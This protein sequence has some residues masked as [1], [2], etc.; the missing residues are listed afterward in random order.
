MRSRNIRDSR[1]R[2]VVPL[3]HR[4]LAALE[5]TVNASRDSSRSAERLTARLE[6]ADDH[7]ASEARRR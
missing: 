1:K 3:L 2:S 5:A 4:D 6:H 7:A